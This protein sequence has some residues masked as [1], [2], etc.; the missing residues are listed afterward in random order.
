[1][2]RKNLTFTVAALVLAG[3]F[4]LFWPRD[5]AP[6]PA[7]P[8]AKATAPVG[9]RLVNAPIT[10]EQI[11][12]GAIWGRRMGQLG[13]KRGEEGASEAPMS[14]VAGNN[15][16]TWVLDQVNGRV[17]HFDSSAVPIA[18]F[19]V[20]ETAQDLAIGPRGNLYVLDRLGKAEVTVFDPNGN[21]IVTDAVV[22]G[23]I[24]EGGAVTGIFVSDKGVYLE[25]EHVQAVRIA[26][27][28]GKFDPDRPVVPGRPTRDGQGYVRVRLVDKK[29]QLAEVTTFELDGKER[30]KRTVSFPRSIVHIVAL[31][32][33]R[34][35]HVLVAADVADT[36]PSPPHDLIN[37]AMVV[38]RL[39]L[40]DGASQ[41]MLTLPTPTVPEETF[42][43]VTVTDDG[44]VVQ[45]LPSHEGVRVATY[46]FP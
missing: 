14:L 1:M 41:G 45:M 13:H 37:V 25:K 17:V 32:T 42:R 6:E 20:A 21:A 18:E 4:W 39:A 30:W 26:G 44:L 16:D 15:G 29:S 43:P 23:P 2:S 40:A 9:P 35:G 10:P 5:R 12:V 11:R 28:D 46:R 33:D 22:G 38:A 34:A 24:E 31:D 36:A 7:A 3:G 8:E 27:L 19:K